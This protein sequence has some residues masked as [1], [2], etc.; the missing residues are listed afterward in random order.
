M[1]SGDGSEE[2][3]VLME[4]WKM[5]DGISPQ[6]QRDSLALGCRISPQ[7]FYFPFDLFQISNPFS[8]TS[9]PFSPIPSP[10]SFNTNI[11]HRTALDTQND[12][13]TQ[14]RC[15]KK[16]RRYRDKLS[17]EQAKRKRN[18][19]AYRKA[20]TRQQKAFDKL[21]TTEAYQN[22]HPSEKEKMLKDHHQQISKID[23]KYRDEGRHP[24]QQ[25]DGVVGA[26]NF[27]LN[28]SSPND[29]DS[30]LEA[31]DKWE[32]LIPKAEKMEDHFAY[33]QAAT[34][35]QHVRQHLISQLESL[36]FKC[37]AIRRTVGSCEKHI[38]CLLRMRKL[39]T[40][41][42][43]YRYTQ[44]L[45]LEG[46]NIFTIQEMATWFICASSCHNMWNTSRGALGTNKKRN[47][48]GPKDLKIRGLKILYPKP[49]SR[50][51]TLFHRK[52][53]LKH[54]V[55]LRPDG[56]RRSRWHSVE[57]APSLATM[58]HEICLGGNAQFGSKEATESDRLGDG[59]FISLP[60]PSWLWTRKSLNGIEQLGKEMDGKGKDLE[61]LFSIL[62]GKTT[63]TRLYRR[64]KM[65]W[66]R[67]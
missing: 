33:A 66:D 58:V 59:E 18:L 64:R 53:S 9:K 41:F 8:S 40:Y 29:R 38:M 6:F 10:F 1:K 61:A 56:R 19:D 14:T 67:R 7:P 5:K 25:G 31:D 17:E 20:I 23:Q 62:T 47:Y 51:A 32:D 44:Y 34:S 60:G 27:G 16:A 42:S 49:T 52:W 13:A 11:S 37:L 35:L 28:T 63:P 50:N 24:N 55:R 54:G 45:S 26:D 3:G 4:M 36:F 39:A 57:W 2:F 30:D 22:A 43:A 21:Q 65:P 46:S 15:A 12:D 48:N